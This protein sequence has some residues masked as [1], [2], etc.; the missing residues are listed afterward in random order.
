MQRVYLHTTVRRRMLG[1]MVPALLLSVLAVG[2]SAEAA[3]V[4]ELRPAAVTGPPADPVN[5][6]SELLPGT[7]RVA[8]AAPNPA[9]AGQ[10]PIGRAGNPVPPGSRVAPV[11]APPVQV[12][13]GMPAT[14]ATTTTIPP[15][16]TTTT[17]TPPAGATTTT[18][19]P[20]GAA[21]AGGAQGGSSTTTTTTPLLESDGIEP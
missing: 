12:P 2:C 8:D 18:S 19:A 7:P 3:P 5:F 21:S 4:E 9:R 16:A 17:S 20:A 1:R 10:Y 15:E 6:Q 13:E 11:T 14:A